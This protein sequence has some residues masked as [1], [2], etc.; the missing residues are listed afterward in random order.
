[1][2]RV[3][4]A[5]EEVLSGGGGA[6]ALGSGGGGPGPGGGALGGPAVVPLR[7][8]HGGQLL[9][10][11]PGTLALFG[12]A[13]PEVAQFIPLAQMQRNVASQQTKRTEI[14]LNFRGSAPPGIRSGDRDQIARVIVDALRAADVEMR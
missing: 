9:A 11:P 1:M 13:Q 12:E 3:E 2:I 7:F 4:V 8:Q 5:F 6:P 14:D 10:K